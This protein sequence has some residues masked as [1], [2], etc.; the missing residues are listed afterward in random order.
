MNILIVTP[1]FKHDRNIAS[2][3]WTNISKRLAKNHNIIVVTQ[4][5]DDMDMTYSKVEEEG[6]LVAR[7]NQKTDYEKFAIRHLGGATGDD[8]QTKGASEV[9]AQQDTMTRKVKNFVLYQSMQKKA[10]DY[11]RFVCKEV[12]PHDCKIDVVISSACPFIE[13][14]IGY[15]LKRKLGC[16]WI[17]DFRDLPFDADDC[18]RTHREKKLM[19]HA[20]KSADKVVTVAKNGKKYLDKHI[21]N[22]S[23]KVVVVTNGFSMSD[24][25]PTT[26]IDDDMLHIIH[27]GSL[28]SGRRRAD[29]LLKAFARLKQTNPDYKFVLD[30]AGGNNQA[31]LQ[32]AK[33]FG[34]DGQVVDKG[35]LP[36][37]EALKL[38]NSADCLVA[39]VENIPGSLSA[40]LFEYALCK[41]P[42]ICVTCG[43]D[44]G[45]DNEDFVESHKLGIAV[46]EKNV[47]RDV[48]ILSAYLKMQL[49]R[50]I[51]KKPLKFEPRTEALQEYNHD[52]IVIKIEELCK[53]LIEK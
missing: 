44:D 15:E 20:L 43:S 4:P 18:D 16:K 13:M 38:Q 37:E 25:K 1:F 34:V 46:K 49:E 9:V 14:L 50:K 5:H 23:D 21:V 10:K 6:I 47:E 26:F 48:E 19:V 51:D 41:K 3:R 53:E 32:A 45:G 31:L 29:L 33:D 7:I 42:I 40:K 17:S 22:D 12:I 30:C 28:Y 27:T 2:V 35:F 52:R 39:F 36:R 24:A 8:W 11:A